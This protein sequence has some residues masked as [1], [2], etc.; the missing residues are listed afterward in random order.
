MRPKKFWRLAL[1]NLFFTAWQHCPAAFG[2]SG[3]HI[4]YH[5]SNVYTNFP[6]TLGTCVRWSSTWKFKLS[7]LHTST[8]VPTTAIRASH[9]YDISSHETFVVQR[10]K[11][12][13]KPDSSG[14]AN[15][16]AR[17]FLHRA[18]TINVLSVVQ[19]FAKHTVAPNKAGCWSPLTMLQDRNVQIYW[20]Q[21]LKQA[22][23]YITLTV[24]RQMSR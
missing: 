21:S 13:I 5:P 8:I 9:I 20:W 23:L 22:P 7:L 14:R 19:S 2:R 3:R 18:M 16:S 1:R 17:V 10:L 15:A 4:L 12:A 6:T 24:D 11:L